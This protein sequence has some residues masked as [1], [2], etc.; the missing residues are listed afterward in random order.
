MVEL[1]VRVVFEERKINVQ[2]K[3]D[4]FTGNGFST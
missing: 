1:E 2:T 3:G 4:L